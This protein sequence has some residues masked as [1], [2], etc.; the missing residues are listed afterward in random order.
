[1]R[2]AK[3]VKCNVAIVKGKVAT[4]S[5]FIRRVSHHTP[6]DAYANNSH[7]SGGENYP[8]MNRGANGTL[9]P[10]F[11]KPGRSRWGGGRANWMDTTGNVATCTKS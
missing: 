1:M 7:S 11:A 2:Q 6:A 8:R 10:A 4:S 5:T 9:L 3:T